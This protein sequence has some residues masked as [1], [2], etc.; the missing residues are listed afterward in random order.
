MIE[1]DNGMNKQIYKEKDRQL[2]EEHDLNQKKIL[3]LEQ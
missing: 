2:M 3:G 1:F